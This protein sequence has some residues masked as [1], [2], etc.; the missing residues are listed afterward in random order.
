MLSTLRIKNLALVAD[1]TLELQPGYNA[2]TGETGAGKSIL[3]G[4]LS[5]VLGERADRTLIRSGCDACSV[6]AVFDVSKLRAPLKCFLDENGLEPCEENQ[7]VLKR[8]FTA[9]GA[10]R[11]FVNGSA[12]TLDK[13]ASIG[14]WLVDMHGPHDHQSLLHTARQL[15]ILDA[16]GGLQEE[17]EAFGELVRKRSVIETEKASLVVDEKTYEQQLDLLRFQVREISDARLQ[18]GED[19]QIEEEHRRS[20]NGAKL[21]QLSQAALDLLAESDSSVLTEAGIVGRTLQELQRIDPGAETLVSLH[22]QATAN[23]RELQSELSRYADKVDV[24]PARLAE[25]EERLN[26]LQS[27]KRKYGPT[28]P[29]VIA[30]GDEA[31]RKLQSLESRDA[32]LARLNASLTKLDAELL[33]AGQ[34]LSAKRKK[35]IPKLSKAAS[36]QLEDLGFK[37]SRLDVQLTTLTDAEIKSHATPNASGFDEIE[38]QF[39]P[40][41][42]EPARPL[43]AIASSGELARVMLALKT[44]LAAADEV[45]VLVFDEVDA[46][47]GG[48]T[49][50]AVGDKMRQIAAKRQVLCITHLPQVAAS[51]D[52][53]F[54]VSK[55]VKEGRTISELTLLD[56]KS[57]VAEL[58]RMLGGQSEAARKHAE[59]M[60]KAR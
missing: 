37:Q 46:N 14:D 1:L 32:E 8:T 27:L 3:I 19:A 6:E 58:A 21:L 30:F 36:A 50:N 4:A 5:L 47:V 55:E 35:V 28:L 2:I 45:P 52:A 59:A 29:E 13:L 51:A 40:N 49:A 56:R 48:E 38:F 31:K 41:P 15:A 23:L 20:A 18:P 16:F 12:T 33:R 26:V 60:L 25:L 43:R 24:D 9:A 53:H 34:Q 57:R 44:V 42:G 39:A 10:N 22:E 54:V 17:R 11:Q 7:L